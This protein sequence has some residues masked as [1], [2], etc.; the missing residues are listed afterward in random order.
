M[1]Q[2]YLKDKFWNTNFL[3][4]ANIE[5]ISGCNMKCKHCYVCDRSEHNK[6]HLLSVETIKD[7]VLQ[8]RDMGV[9]RIGLTGGEPLTH[10][11]IFEIIEF[12][13]DNNISL[14]MLSNITLIDENN[15]DKIA[16]YV[17]VI[18]T[19]KYG[20]DEQS[21]E[22]LTQTKGSYARYTKAV[23]LIKKSNI[24]LMERGILLY[25]TEKDIN[26]MLNETTQIETKIDIR[27]NNEYAVR[28]LPSKKGLL[29]YYKI[30]LEKEGQTEKDFENLM[31][32]NVCSAGN[33]FLFFNS[34]GDIYACPILEIPLGNIYNDRIIDVWNSE[35]L[36]KIKDLTKLQNFKKC[37]SCEKR[38]YNSHWC[39]ATNIYETGECF[40]PSK[41]S[42]MHCEQYQKACLEKNIKS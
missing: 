14:S 13:K 17:E 39:I 4:S 2:R 28:A 3:T 29:E 22:D 15:I 7:I 41:Y 21:Y 32:K 1:L 30:L 25:N 23:E 11:H 40:T 36:K 8:L 16:K 20:F 24:L 18:H 35:Y 5:I 31:E 10:P 38:K 12:I 42:C 6:V 19:T 9:I 26:R 37:I 27:K 34:I 33:N